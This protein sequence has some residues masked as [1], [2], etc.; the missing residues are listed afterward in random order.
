MRLL[1][2]I[3]T[4][5]LVLA[6]SFFL[7]LAP[8][9]AATPV[10]PQVPILMYHYI[11]N[12]QNPR[13]PVGENLSVAPAL[14]AQQMQYLSSHGYTPITLDK[15]AAIFAGKA[16]APAKPI[17]LTFDDG[18]KDLFTTAFP[19]LQRYGF[20]AV[21]FVI[22][23]FVGWHGYVSWEDIQHM[24]TSGL[25]SFEAHTVHHTY[26]PA[27]SYQQA[28]DELFTCKK[29]LQAETGSPV[30]FLAYP[31]GAT[32]ATVE[33][34]V[35]KAGYVG[36]LGTWFAKAGEISFDMPRVRIPGGISLADFAL[37]VQ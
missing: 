26:L 15:L 11:R 28:F 16:H 32:D 20:H 12:D 25:I 24:Q 33:S 10:I 17:V 31:D 30:N 7:F 23:G 5:L 18:Y 9:Y 22:T 36:A 37:R 27:V 14:F 3:S 21:S 29:T 1:S 8:A 35:Q 19:I 2:K 4:C 34:A 6:S 13:D